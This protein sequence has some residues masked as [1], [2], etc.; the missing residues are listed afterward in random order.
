[1]DNGNIYMSKENDSYIHRGEDFYYHNLENF[2]ND[3]KKK[4]GTQ[5]MLDEV[6]SQTGL[7]Y[8]SIDEM[9]EKEI[10][11]PYTN[12]FYIDIVKVED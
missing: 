4:I 7:H 10:M 9:I 8:S 12:W 5:E 2:Y 6:N 1:L 3:L 11:I